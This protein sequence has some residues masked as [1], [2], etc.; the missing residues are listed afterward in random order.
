MGKII[1]YKSLVSNRFG[2]VIGKRHTQLGEKILCEELDSNFDFIIEDGKRKVF[3]CSPKNVEQ[4]GYLDP[5]DELFK[6]NMI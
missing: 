1:M 3:M 2:H 6:K 5:V 4:V